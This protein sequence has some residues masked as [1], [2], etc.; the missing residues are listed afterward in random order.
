MMGDVKG[1]TVLDL[2]CGEGYYSRVFAELGAQVTGI[3]FS[4]EIVNAA[5]EEE[6]KRLSE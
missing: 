4:E 1:K 3:D 5:I 2:G 6:L